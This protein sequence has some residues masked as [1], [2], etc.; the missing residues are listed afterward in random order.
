[1]DNTFG[2]HNTRYKIPIKFTFR[3]YS[4]FSSLCISFLQQ[5]HNGFSMYFWRGEVLFILIFFLQ[6]SNCFQCTIYSEF[7][8]KLCHVKFVFNIYLQ[9]YQNIFLPIKN[10]RNNLKFYAN[11]RLLTYR[12]FYFLNLTYTLQKYNRLYYKFKR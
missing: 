10:T 1:M 3:E 8:F 4:S 12:F 6:L 2:F 9:F 7:I 11:M 5:E